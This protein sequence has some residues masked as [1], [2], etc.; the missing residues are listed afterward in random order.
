MQPAGLKAFEA[1]QEYRSGIYAYEHRSAQLPPEYEKLLKKNKAAFQFFEAQPASYRKIVYWYVLSA[2]KEE[3]RLKRL[4]S[5]IEH[6]ANGRR[7]T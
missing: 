6:S 4:N 7:I 1:R 2:K 3:T 5:V